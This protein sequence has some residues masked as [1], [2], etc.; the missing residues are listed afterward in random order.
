VAARLRRELA[1]DV[2]AIHGRYG[3]YK[4]LVDGDVVVDGGPMVMLG[5]M[6]PSRRIVETVRDRLA[7][8]SSTP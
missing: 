7:S 8:P 3:E 2:D 1:I 6:P 5:V 4:V